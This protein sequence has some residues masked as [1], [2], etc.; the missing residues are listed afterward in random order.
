MRILAG[1]DWRV[2]PGE[3]WALV[4]PN[5]AGKTSLL[6]IAGA[7]VHPS[8]GRA[9]VLGRPLGSTDLRELR[10]RV[11]HLDAG[12]AARFRPRATAREVVLSGVT[13]TILVR[14]ARVGPAERAAADRL[15]ESMGC[16]H[17]ADRPFAPLSRGEQQRVLLARALVSDPALLLLDEP[18]AGLDLPGREAFLARLDALAETRPALATV[19]VSH[20]VE[21]LPA[22]L[23]HA[24]L[25]RRGRV[26]AAGPAASVLID[27]HLSACF[28]APVRVT[29]AGGRRMAVIA[30]G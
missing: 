4:G 15:L 27:E 1:I 10:M 19:H 22:G 8:E 28:G 30:P 17:L 26:V 21:E 6:R 13:A 18:T 20:H 16:A 11:G 25:L 12:L 29:A 14:P 23:T 3:R 9:S 5:G 24:L 2:L 7:E